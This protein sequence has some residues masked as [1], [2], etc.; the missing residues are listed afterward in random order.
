M[1][2]LKKKWYGVLEASYMLNLGVFAAATFYVQQSGGNQAIVVYISTNIAFVS[3][4]I[5]L[6]YDACIDQR[7]KVCFCC[8]LRGKVCWFTRTRATTDLY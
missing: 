4:L 6:V 2:K 3:F 7:G 8:R 5:T 1:Y